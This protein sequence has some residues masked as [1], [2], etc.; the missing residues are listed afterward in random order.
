MVRARLFHW[1]DAHVPSGGRTVLLSLLIVFGVSRAASVWAQ[2]EPLTL[3]PQYTMQEWGIDEGL[4]VNSVYALQIGP[5]GFLWLATHDGLV[6]FDGVQFRTFTVSTTPALPSNRIRRLWT[7]PNGILWIQTDGRVLVRYQNQRFTRMDSTDGLPRGFAVLH[8]KRIDGGVAVGSAD[9]L[10]RYDPATERFV[11]IAPDSIRTTALS[12]TYGDDGS[13]WVGT[14]AGALV[15]LAP[16]QADNWRVIQRLPAATEPPASGGQRMERFETPAL[17]RLVHDTDDSVWLFASRN[18]ARYDG[19][20]LWHTTRSGSPY[21]RS[22][23]FPEGPYVLQSWISAVGP[24]AEEGAWMSTRRRTFHLREA[25]ASVMENAPTW[26]VVDAADTQTETTWRSVGTSLFHGVTEVVSGRSLQTPAVVDSSG[27]LWTASDAGLARIAPARFRTYSIEEGLPSKSAYGL[28]QTQ[29]GSIWVTTRPGLS[30]LEPRTGRITNI[31]HPTLARVQ[32]ETV[33]QERD[34]TIWLATQSG[35]CRWT[36]VGCQFTGHPD[37]KH[38][39]AMHQDRSGALWFAASD[40]GLFRRSPADTSR[41]ERFDASD[42]LPSQPDI[43]R[44]VETS[45]G[46]LWVSTRT[47]GIARFNGT[48]FETLDVD[49]SL[50]IGNV[51]EIYEAPSGVLWLGTEGAGLVRLTVDLAPLRVRTLHRVTRSDGLLGNSIHR[52][53]PDDDGRLWM[54]TN[55]GMFWVLYDDL[56]RFATHATGDSQVHVTSYDTR[57]GLRNREANGGVQGAGIRARD[58]TL[59]FPTQDGIAGLHPR[60]EPSDR[61]TPQPFIEDVIANRESIPLSSAASV[62]LAAHQRTFAIRFVAPALS[63]PDDVVYRYRLEGFEDQWMDRQGVQEAFYTDV[64]PGRYRFRVIAEREATTDREAVLM[65]HVVPR[66]Y[67]QNAFWIVLIALEL[68]L[69]I[70]A[71]RYRIVQEEARANELEAEVH[72]RTQEL[73]ERSE[74]LAAARDE[75]ERAREE[76][77]T[78]NELKSRFLAHVTHDLRTPLIGILGF[79]E[80]LRSETE[81]QLQRFAELIERSA[82]RSNEMVESLLRLSRLQAEAHPIEVAPMDLC[83]AVRGAV[84]MLE[85]R[86]HIAE[87]VV[88]LDVPEFPVRVR[89]NRSAVER[90]VENLVGNGIKYSQPGDRVTVLVYSEASHAVLEVR[91]SGPGIVA[92]FLPHLFEP[93][94]RNASDDE[95]SGLGLAITHEMVKQMGGTITVNSTVGE[96]TCFRVRLPVP[97]SRPAAT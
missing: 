23:I 13:L 62:R 17:R 80:M 67:E 42:G 16:A 71:V 55:Q 28:H 76:A 90:I 95:G 29:D 31:S 46:A 73:L 37:M 60:N 52:I 57:D 14:K 61:P 5:D 3:D 49:D 7:S 87:V 44:I 54:S 70:T 97:P 84:G 27:A 78:A 39:R 9:G 53:L 25:T 75:A 68:L 85:H 6:R 58:G 93:F 47:Q 18:V 40:V 35:P 69:V 33:F 74:E 65:V 77:E 4:P 45:D 30:R 11:S 15:H 86:A 66:F 91:D 38:G 10:R 94:A 19:E 20:R 8:Q 43:N 82:R 41:W 48:R 63:R 22:S 83:P 12:L 2:E 26:W 21:P 96:G 89:G 79:A 92:D 34:G 24:H 56:E 72:S 1:R 88:T 51:R 36:S 32:I 50:P 59:W 64:P 81:G